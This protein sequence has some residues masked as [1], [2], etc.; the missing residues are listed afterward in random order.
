MTNGLRPR[1]PPWRAAAGLA[2]AGLALILVAAPVRAAADAGVF[3]IPAASP[4]RTLGADYFGTHLHRLRV[5]PALHGRERQTPWPAGLVGA[6]RLWDARTRWADVEPAPGRFEFE[7]LDH[8]VTQALAH[9]ASVMLVLGSTPRWASARPWE[10]CPYGSGC[11]AEPSDLRDWERYVEAVAQ[12][13]KGRIAMYELWNEPYFSDFPK[14]RGHPGAFFSGSA[15]TLVEMARIARAVLDRVDPEAVLLTPGFTGPTHRLELFLSRGGARY[16]GGVAYHYYVG[17]DRDFADLHRRV[18]AVMARHG[19]EG[20]PLYNTESGHEWLSP[21]A[22]GPPLPGVQRF[23]EHG[24]AAQLASSLVLGAF[25]GVQGYYQFAWDNTRMGL[26]QADGRGPTAGLQAYANVRRWLVGAQLGGC[27]SIEPGLV[28]CR[29]QRGE[30]QVSLLWRPG[31]R[32]TTAFALP[33]GLEVLGVEDA[34]AG[35]IAPTARTLDVGA[36]PLAVQTRADWALPPGRTGA[37]R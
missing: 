17:T 32:T 29:L 23:D 36:V 2:L 14:D 21:A 5:P 12:R 31:A 16:V 24:M 8:Y 27:A 9:A 19:L 15:D 10:P 28:R 11:L 7:Q 35:P 22:A 1:L 26:L 3:D 37:G 18:R 6:L 25:L 20:L 4:P 13:Y 33:A 34:I 30:A